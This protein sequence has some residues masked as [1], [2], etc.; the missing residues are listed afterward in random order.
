MTQTIK[1]IEPNTALQELMNGNKEALERWE[2][3]DD[4]VKEALNVFAM[5]P[6]TERTRLF[7]KLSMQEDEI[8]A[9]Q[10]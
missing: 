3:A 10:A 4:I 2:K 6:P 9:A 1:I 5:L 8:K 7:N